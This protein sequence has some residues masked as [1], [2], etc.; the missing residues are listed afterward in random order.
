MVIVE[1]TISQILYLKIEVLNK[2][3]IETSENVLLV[4]QKSNANI[5]RAKNQNNS[6]L[7]LNVML[8]SRSLR[9]T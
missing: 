1:N 8:V 7:L 4:E 3:L 5:Y 6:F 9:I 2:T